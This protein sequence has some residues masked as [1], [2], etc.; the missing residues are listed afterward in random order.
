[1]GPAAL[2]VPVGG[3][4]SHAAPA[5]LQA[6]ASTRRPVASLQAAPLKT[7]AGLCGVSQYE[8]WVGT[9]RL[10]SWWFFLC[11]SIAVASRCEQI[12]AQMLTFSLR[13]LQ[14]GS[15]G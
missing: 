3:Q 4:A 10:W 7:A 12:G 2:V 11:A 15:F 5:R 6:P 14:N 9:D 1:M 8:H 13:L